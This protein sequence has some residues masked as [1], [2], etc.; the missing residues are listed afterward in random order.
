[1]T[2][3]MSRKPDIA[4]R[5]GAR[6][7]RGEGRLERVLLNRIRLKGRGVFGSVRGTFPIEDAGRHIPG[8][9]A[10]LE[11]AGPAPGALAK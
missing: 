1:M 7:R 11:R 3:G 5:Q 4:V 10:E 9:Y 6:P 2:R 8:S